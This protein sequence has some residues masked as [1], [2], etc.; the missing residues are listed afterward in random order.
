[1]LEA[2]I[3]T[4]RH[5]LNVLPW[6]APERVVFSNFDRLVFTSLYRLV[7][8]IRNTFVIVNPETVIRWRHVE[9]KFVSL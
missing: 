5:Q 4:L 3:L 9:L 1:M 7:P 6:K 2:E 8:G